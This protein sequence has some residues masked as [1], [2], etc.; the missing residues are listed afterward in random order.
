[1]LADKLTSHESLLHLTMIANQLR[2]Q[3]L[4]LGV[5]AQLLLFALF[6]C[7]VAKMLQGVPRVSMLFFE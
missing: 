5:V 1:M 6:L 4:H 2:L 3:L 7:G